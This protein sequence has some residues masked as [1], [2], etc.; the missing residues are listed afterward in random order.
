MDGLYSTFCH[1]PSFRR[2][3]ASGQKVS[4]RI[5]AARQQYFCQEKIIAKKII[6]T[7]RALI[8]QNTDLV[9][10]TSMAQ[11]GVVAAATIHQASANCL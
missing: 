2:A 9:Y 5:I 3:A 8:S 10:S 4:H 6:H 11:L 7:I 1:V